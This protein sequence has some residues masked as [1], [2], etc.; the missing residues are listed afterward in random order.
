MLTERSIDSIKD[1][2]RQSI[3]QGGIVRTNGQKFKFASIATITP[4]NQQ[5]LAT[6]HIKV[7]DDKTEGSFTG[8]SVFNQRNKSV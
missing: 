3:T 2:P 7:S 6:P 5:P 8:R 4:A 1:S